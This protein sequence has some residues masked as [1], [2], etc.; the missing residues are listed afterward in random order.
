MKEPFQTISPEQAKE[1]IDT[2]SVTILD[3]REPMNFLP[4]TFPT[5][6]IYLL[7]IYAGKPQMYS[8]TC[9]AT[10]LVYCSSGMHSATA[11]IVLLDLAM[12]MFMILAE[13]PL[14]LTKSNHNPRKGAYFGSF[15]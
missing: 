8:G 2:A 9:F 1:L 5:P 6:A 15:F 3:V 10:I 7:A 14:G 12:R 13:S 4:D 11:C